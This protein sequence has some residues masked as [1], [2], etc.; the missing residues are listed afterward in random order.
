V[1]VLGLDQSSQTTGYSV[2]EDGKLITFGHFTFT[3]SS[4]GSRL[5]KIREKV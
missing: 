3:D 2:F 4:L 5:M 1:R